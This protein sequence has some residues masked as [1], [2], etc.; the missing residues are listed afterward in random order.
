[1]AASLAQYCCCI[2]C[3]CAVVMRYGHRNSDAIG[4]SEY[5]EKEGALL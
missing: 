4:I 2:D 1:M 3:A 5:C